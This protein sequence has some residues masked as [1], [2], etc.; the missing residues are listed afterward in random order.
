MK[1]TKVL[2]IA[3]GIAAIS[4]LAACTNDNEPAYNNQTPQ[5]NSL[6]V[7][8]PD[9]KAWSGSQD[10]LGGNGAKKVVA[11]GESPAAVTS[12]EVAAAKAY[13][14]AKDNWYP[15]TG[16]N[17]LDI[18]DLSSW[19]SY[20]V[21]EVASGNRLP[22]DVAIYVGTNDETIKNIAVWNIDA[23]EVLKLLKT[24]AYLDNA[25]KVEVNPA[26]ATLVKN[27]A[28]KDFSFETD[29][30]TFGGVKMEGVRSS[31]HN[32]QYEW[33]PNYKIAALDGQED[34]VYVALYGYTD[35]NNG[36]WNRII[37]LTK[38]EVADDVEVPAEPET[39]DDDVVVSDKVLHN[40][41]VEVNLSIND[42]HRYYNVE[43]LTSKLSIHV[44]SAK[45]VKVRIPVPVEIL[46]PADDLDIVMARPDLLVYGEDN[47]ASFEIN[48]N[49]VELFVDFTI[50]TDCAGNG[51][52]CYI[53][54]TTKG[55]NKDVINYCMENY[56]DGVN[57]EIYNYYQ[58]N[59]EDAEGNVTNYKPT[60]EEIKD[61]KEKWLD[62]ATVEF[63]YDNGT[64]M[65]YT[66]VNDYPYYYINSFYGDSDCTV[67]VI[68]N[69]SYAYENYYVG[70]HL[71]G[72][73]NNVV[74]VR[75]DIWGTE[76]QD[77]AHNPDLWK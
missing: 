42:T 70:E 48:G 57:F 11:L 16:G 41:E 46:V 63:G 47:H 15:T 61:L 9:I 34:A 23:D 3:A 39:G 36:F 12:G 1:F 18:S 53:E 43:D 33:Q 58:W 31:G 35:S 73:S 27:H 13:F 6:L 29:G 44:R 51:Y 20:Y 14:N 71:N 22:N 7:S 25:A 28:I 55:I 37:K 64:W 45:D 2:G 4:Q 8:A 10:L 77:I 17:D 49:V 5:S 40:N 38:A 26:E 59:V 62:K 56:A 54:V 50:A 69:Q 76:K 52:G 30:Y 74:Y 72:S 32:G 65:A 24:D 67:S 66:N 68:S 19:T 21:Q 75:E 60:A